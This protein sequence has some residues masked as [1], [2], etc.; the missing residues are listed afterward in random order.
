MIARYHDHIRLEDIAWL[1]EGDE[2]EGRY[3]V[4]SE[5]ER[6]VVVTRV[7]RVNGRDLS[8]QF[9]IDRSCILTR[10]LVES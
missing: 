10:T 6:L 9:V 8:D 5:G 3:R 4:A 2:T 1:D 7:A